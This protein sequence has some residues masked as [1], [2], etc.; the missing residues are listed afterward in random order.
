MSQNYVSITFDG[1]H[2]YPKIKINSEEISRY[3][4]LSDL[5]YDDI[6][7]WGNSF[8]SAIDDELN[9]PYEVQL[10][11]YPFQNEYTP[12]PSLAPWRGQRRLSGGWRLC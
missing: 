9:E 8:F 1:I 3:M 6:F 10:V 4:E 12:V 7:I 2:K 11:G 5:I